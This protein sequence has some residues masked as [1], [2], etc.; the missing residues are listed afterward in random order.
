MKQPT[1]P[2]PP[3][4]L[5]PDTPAQLRRALRALGKQD[6]HPARLGRVAGRLGDLLDAPPPTPFRGGALVRHASLKVVAARLALA[7][8][9]VGTTAAVWLSSSQPSA[10]GP[11]AQHVQPAPAQGTQLTLPVQR[12]DS[13]AQVA[14]LAVPAAAR[15]PVA[16][17]STQAIVELPAAA[18]G[19]TS[20]RAGPSRSRHTRPAHR[21]AFSQ[22]RSPR[23]APGAAT[24]AAEAATQAAQVAQPVATASADARRPEAAAPVSPAPAALDPETTRPL[25]EVELLFEAR[26]QMRRH[27][28]GAL[29]LLDEH[30]ARFAEGLLAPERE[31]LAIEALRKLG[32][33]KVAAQRLRSFRERYPDSLHLRRLDRVA[34]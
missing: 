7:A 15:A 25:T 10:R 20:R 31:V 18:H 8:L 13:E 1:S 16:R 27:P 23:A 19:A 24:R 5:G 2:P 30:A 34:P 11:S 28:Q 4:K 12:T 6:T 33:P 3:L 32:R 21:V 14:A 17:V 9:T 29:E 26:Q 22:G